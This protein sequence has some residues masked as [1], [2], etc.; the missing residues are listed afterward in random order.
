[1]RRESKYRA[2]QIAAGTKTLLY[3]S[4]AKNAKIGRDHSADILTLYHP[5]ARASRAAQILASPKS[6][7]EGGIDSLALGVSPQTFGDACGPTAK[8][9][10]SLL[11]CRPYYSFSLNGIDPGEHHV[12]GQSR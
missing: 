6:G 5:S 8:C 9:L 4:A 3:G 7:G 11:L 2:F 10:I 12:T 1:M